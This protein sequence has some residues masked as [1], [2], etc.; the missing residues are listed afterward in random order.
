MQ[1]VQCNV[2]E[3]I[4]FSCILYDPLLGLILLHEIQ[5]WITS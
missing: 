5:G 4:L 3:N 1:L 2:R